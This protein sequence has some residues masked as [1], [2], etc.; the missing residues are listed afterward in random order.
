MKR[1]LYLE[2]TADLRELFTIFLGKNGWEVITCEDGIEALFIYHTHL[3]QDEFFDAI[4]LD[5]GVPKLKGYV[6]GVNIR[7]VETYGDRVPKARHVY[8]SAHEKANIP[9]ELEPF[10]T[11]DAYLLKP[12]EPSDLLNALDGASQAIVSPVRYPL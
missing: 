11:P 9:V 2:D 10:L 3:D 1:L 6:A 12:C 8:L 5:I 7:N 4:L